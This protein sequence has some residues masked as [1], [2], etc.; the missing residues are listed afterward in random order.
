M[1]YLPSVRSPSRALARGRKPIFTSAAGK[2]NM[3]ESM[4]RILLLLMLAVLFSFPVRAETNTQ[5]GLAINRLVDFCALHDLSYSVAR[6]TV[7]S[8]WTIT[9]VLADDKG[10][11]RVWSEQGFPSVGLA[12]TDVIRDYQKFPRG[13]TRTYRP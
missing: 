2:G 11:D 9:V 12:V 10:N 4:K 7:K 13:F 3:K 5:R 6:Q 1:H 8:P